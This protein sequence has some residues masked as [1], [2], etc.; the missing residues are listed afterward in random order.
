MVRSRE[1]GGRE[2]GDRG[3]RSDFFE[4]I[5]GPKL[6]VLGADPALLARL[7][8]THSDLPP[9]LESLFS[10]AKDFSDSEEELGSEEARICGRAA[11][12]VARGGTARGDTARGDTGGSLGDWFTEPFMTRRGEGQ[13]LLWGQRRRVP[14]DPAETW[15]RAVAH[16]LRNHQTAVVTSLYG[17]SEPA[18]PLPGSGLPGG[19]PPDPKGHAACVEL[20]SCG[21]SRSIALLEAFTAL[22]FPVPEQEMSTVGDCFR[23]FETLIEP[24]M[25]RRHASVHL[26]SARVGSTLVEGLH[27]GRALSAVAVAALPLLSRGQ[28]LSVSG[29]PV[30]ADTVEFGVSLDGGGPEGPLLLRERLNAMV[31][32]APDEPCRI[33]IPRARSEEP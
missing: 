21:I 14:P 19:G 15:G 31:P 6:E 17:L 3:S 24:R 30:D 26:D 4:L 9:D 29:R 25:R 28:R 33:S 5:L 20:A 12:A 11:L 32:L 23:W 7:G 13:R 22:A 1:L 16:Q 18:S 8:W 2:A 10:G 27:A